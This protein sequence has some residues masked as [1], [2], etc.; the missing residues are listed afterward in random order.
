[1]VREI[2]NKSH[3][4]DVGTPAI[5]H[6]VVNNHREEDQNRV[7][8]MGTDDA[9]NSKPNGRF[10]ADTPT[11][12][13]QNEFLR[14]GTW[15]VRTLYQAGKLDNLRQEFAKLKLNILGITETHWT[16]S[17]IIQ[18]E[19]S[20]F[21]HSGGEE[22]RRGVGIMLNKKTAKCLLGYWPIS[23]RAIMCKIQARPFNIVILQC[24][25]PTADQSQEKIDEFY[26]EIETALK[27]NKS[28]DIVIILGDFNAKVGCTRPSD[29][30]GS[31]GLGETNE[32]GDALITFCEQHKFSVVNTFFKN[33]KRHRSIHLEKPWRCHKEPNRL[34]TY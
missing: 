18:G 23:E 1:M 27:Q 24:Y 30:V 8:D 20:V 21:I 2:N 5:R 9:A 26:M 22:H 19:E 29:C 31:Y 6:L 28:D 10:L 14:V 34:Y 11:L 16:E 15:N 25:A 7:R 3:T 4:R 17:G 13:T 12:K 32:R 33:S